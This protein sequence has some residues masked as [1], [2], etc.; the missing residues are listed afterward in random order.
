MVHDDQT[1]YYQRWVQSEIPKFA[2]VYV[3]D[4]SGSMDNS[5]YKQAKYAMTGEIY[6]Y[7]CFDAEASASK[8]YVF[9][10][11]YLSSMTPSSSVFGTIPFGHA[12]LSQIWAE[13]SPFV[14]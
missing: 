3:L 14:D 6:E 5:N 1:F 4:T 10:A 9:S 8:M 2:T 7:N 12:T 13:V 11:A